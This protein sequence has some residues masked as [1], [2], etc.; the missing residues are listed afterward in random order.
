MVLEQ[1]HIESPEKILEQIKLAKAKLFTVFKLA[2][3]GNAENIAA[4]SLASMHKSSTYNTACHLTE[5]F[6]IV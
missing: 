1:E 3:A 2:L 6:L 5:A 4:V